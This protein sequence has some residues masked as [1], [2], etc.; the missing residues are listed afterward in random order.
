MSGAL[1]IRP[2]LLQERAELEALRWRASLIW[3]EYRQALLA[4]PDA[5][6]LPDEQIGASQVH[7]GVQDSG[8]VGFS[9]VLA[10]SDGDAELDGLFVDPPHWRR[11]IGARLV[12]H[13]AALAKDAGARMLCVIANPRA[14]GFYLSSGFRTVGREAT[15]FGDADRMVKALGGDVSAGRGRFATPGDRR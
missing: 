4:N 8:L 5:I 12:D 15:R 1:H 3:E 2:A 9:V 7:V 6:E 13:A 10:R 11:G 14:E